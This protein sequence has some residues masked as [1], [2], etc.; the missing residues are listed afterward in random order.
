MSL[1]LEPVLVAVGEEGEGRLAFHDD[2]LVAVLVRIP[3]EDDGGETG[4]W[5]LEKGFGPL[6]SPVHV[7]FPDLEAAEAWLEQRLCEST[8][9]G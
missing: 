7:S 8:T 6:D 4:W 5:F 3:P 2:R 1:R 9:R